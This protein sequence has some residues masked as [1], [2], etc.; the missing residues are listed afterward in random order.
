MPIMEH[1]MIMRL[2]AGL[3]LHFWVDVVGNDV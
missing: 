1:A 2:H 3:P